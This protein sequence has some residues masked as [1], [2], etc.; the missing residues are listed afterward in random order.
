MRA[1]L[2]CLVMLSGFFGAEA[3]Q[4]QKELHI[5]AAADLQP[6]MPVLAEAYEHAT[7]I[8][9][10]VSYGSSATLTTQILNG[11]PMDIFLAA[12]FIFP[13]KIVAAGLSD[14]KAP[15][16]YAKGAL[17]LWARKD[18]PLQPISM[19]KLTDPRVTRI[20][21][22][23]EDHA[24]YGRAAVAALKKLNIYD[25]VSSHLVVAENIAQTAQFVES[26]NAQLG[27]ISLTTAST[28]HFKEIGTY[29]LVPTV[30]PEM[31]QCAV[32]MAKS[33]HRAEAHA[34]LD[35]LLTPAVQGNMSKLGL[36]AVQ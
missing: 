28:A 36:S 33:E 26:G 19:D 7:G 29:V 30:Y 24:P 15:T 6:V 12:D 17:V 13:E 8:K 16:A 32:V 11:A 2:L 25:K 5:A 34:F 3:A 35:W 31:R 14:M 18:S 10:V 22:A 23:N 4:G 20:A 21:I 1:V 9:L 27:L